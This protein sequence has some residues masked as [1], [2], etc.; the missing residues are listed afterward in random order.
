[1]RRSLLKH[2]RLLQLKNAGL[3]TVDFL[4]YPPG[5]INLKEISDFFKKHG[6]I[7]FRQYTNDQKV[8]NLPEIFD[9]HDLYELLNFIQINRRADS[10]MI[11]NQGVDMDEETIRGCFRWFDFYAFGIEY[12]I[13]PGNP[14]KIEKKTSLELVQ[15]Y[16]DT[17]YG[18]DLGKCNN[19]DGK[20]SGLLKELVQITRS[21]LTRIRPLIIEFEWH[22]SP[23]GWKPDYWLFWEWR[24]DHLSEQ[25]RLEKIADLFIKPT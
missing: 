10:Y 2:E 9:V 19:W 20:Y 23:I 7:S 11:V 16:G 6:R 3:N 12:F 14:R 15:I 13:G 18:F 24:I 8:G 17:E 4:W 22:A 1:M 5:M 25:K 21:F